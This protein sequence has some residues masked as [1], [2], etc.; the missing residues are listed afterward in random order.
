VAKWS[1][2]ALA[3]QT[4]QY[5]Q[6]EG[7]RFDLDVGEDVIMTGPLHAAIANGSHVEA[8]SMTG[9]WKPSGPITA[10][11][12]MAQL[13]A[14]EVFV[15]RQA[16]AEAERAVRTRELRRA[17]A[18]IVRDLAQAGVEV[19]SV[20]DLV[21][22]S[23]PYPDALPVLLNHLQ[24]GGYPDRVM[25]SMGRAIAVKASFAVWETLRDLYLGADSRGAEEGLAVALAASAGSD[26]F[27]QLVDL[28]R[29]DSRSQTRIH[30]L[31][32]IKRVGGQA[33]RKILEALKDHPMFGQEAR[34]LLRVRRR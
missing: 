23:E 18:P 32:P 13:A 2:E 31:E 9:Q 24:Q 4:A 30:F 19:T 25:E 8:H 15:R 28:L 1:A 26:H 16:A 10:A 7:L 27:G 6:V 20:W 14:D 21:N 17:E 5:A 29:E 22:T 33:G 11:E 12:L 34:A 3:T